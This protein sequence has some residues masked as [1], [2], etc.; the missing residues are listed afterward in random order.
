[1]AIKV[2]A[3]VPDNLSLKI[4]KIET[5]CSAE[6]YVQVLEGNMRRMGLDQPRQC[7]K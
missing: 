1:L 5:H 4:V 3:A 7:L 2:T 6:E